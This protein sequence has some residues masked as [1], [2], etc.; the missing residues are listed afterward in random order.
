M[1]ATPADWTEAEREALA[2]KV[3]ALIGDG[4]FAPVFAAGSRAEVSIA[5]R[6]ERR[7]GRRRWFPGRS[8]GWW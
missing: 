4:R 6:L 1:P 8:T 3:L 7:D 2:Q 5:G